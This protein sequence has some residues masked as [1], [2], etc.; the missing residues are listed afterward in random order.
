MAM[1]HKK[2]A[3]GQ[4]LVIVLLV[5]SIM[6]IFIMSV[7]VSARRDVFERVTNEKYEQ[8]YSLSENRLLQLVQDSK[9]SS[10]I[11]FLTTKYPATGGNGCV[12]NAGTKTYNCGFSDAAQANSVDTLKTD[13]AIADTPN[14]TDLPI[15]KDSTFLIALVPGTNQPAITMSWT[16]AK[17]AWDISLDIRNTNTGEFFALKDVYDGSGVITQGQPSPIHI[18][19]F[20]SGTTNAVSFGLTNYTGK[21]G[22]YQMQ[23]MRIRPIIK[24]GEQSTQLT[25]TGPTLPQVRQFTAKGISSVTSQTGNTSPTVILQVQ[26][27]LNPAPVEILDYVLRSETDVRKP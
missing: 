13:V 21:Q 16:G 20:N 3:N 11:T 24:S 15:T 18:L 7:A 17:V 2:K 6:A 19:S 4:I 14:I 8:Y 12:Y 5:L 10:N 26:L 25:M 23:D 22:S 27:P 1:R 9:I